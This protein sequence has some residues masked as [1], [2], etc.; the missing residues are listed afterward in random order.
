MW[1]RRGVGVLDD[2]DREIIR[3]LQEDGR[4]PLT[5]IAARLQL[6]EGTVRKRLTR[7][8]RE[9]IIRLT[10][11]VD[12][13]KVGKTTLALVGVKVDADRGP[14]I[15]EILAKFPEVRYLAFSAG[16]YDLLLEV[17]V[18]SNEELFHFLTKRL[19]QVDGV[20]AS[21]SSL[22]L[23]TVKEAASWFGA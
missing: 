13:A 14:E 10:A 21:D 17:A 11:V 1:E 15:A 9:R 23:G 12:P 16:E 4:M 3:F 20:K 2:I 19:R 8:V 22:I 5:D 6:A 7:L 18:Q